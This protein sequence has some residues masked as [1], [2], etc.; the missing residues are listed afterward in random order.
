MGIEGENLKGVKS[1]VEFLRDV[2]LGN[3]VSVGQKVAVIGGGN[4]AI[5][6]AR[7]ALRLGAKEV[8]ILY[9]RSR[10]EMPAAEEE[11]VDAEEE[12]I[13]IRYLAAPRK[14]ISTNDQVSAIECIEMELTEP[15]DSGRRKPVPI[16]GSEFKLD[17]DMVIP[18]IGQSPDLSFIDSDSQIEF[19]KKSTINTDSETLQTNNPGVFA[20]GDAVLGPATVIEAIAAGKEAALSIDRYL[21][22]A[23]LQLGRKRDFTEVEVSIEGREKSQRKQT[24]KLS[25]EERVKDFRE[26]AQNWENE[27]AKAEAERCLDCGICSECYQCVVACQANAIDHSMREELLELEVGSLVLAPGFEP[28]DATIKPELGYGQMPNVVT[29]IQFERIL[30]ASG[31]FQGQV[32]RPSDGKHPVK[33]A[34]IQ[35]VGSRDETCG[36]D[37]CSSVCCMYAIKQAIIA[38]EHA[39]EIEPT[40]FFMDIRAHGKGFE[41]YYERAQ[42]E[43]GV[44]FI[45]SRVPRILEEV[46][47]SL[48]VRYTD[49]TSV[50]E[51]KFDMV[52]LSVGLVPSASTKDLAEK[53]AISLDRFGFCETEEFKPN[54]TSRPGI[55]VAGAFDSPMDIPESVMHASSAAYLASQAIVDARGTLVTDKEYPPEIDIAGQEPRVGVFVCRCGTNIARVIDVPGVAEYARGLPYVVSIRSLC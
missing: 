38:K 40:I 24:P 54:V 17:I 6:S 35:C 8:T 25:P 28:F 16:E 3:P 49:D 1:G 5:D 39:S 9:R 53:L 14:I 44:R 41:G 21:R 47:G 10:Q 52:V 7:T 50:S 4:V 42:K 46:D 29:S 32:M 33:I 11:I 20:C 34:W 22:G 36:R 27:V 23:D 43:H 55:Y 45:R 2:N 30:S 31:P 12:G 37:Y 13:K 18:A 48:L 15:D 51:E 26:V 19:S